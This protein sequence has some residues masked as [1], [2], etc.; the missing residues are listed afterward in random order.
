MEQTDKNKQY[1][2]AL[3]VSKS[4]QGTE[5]LKDVTIR[6]EAGTITGIVGRNGSGKS[7]FFKCLCG[8]MRFTSG[9]VYVN[10]KQIKDPKD[11][12]SIGFII[13]EPGFLPQ[14]TGYQNL[15]MLAYLK[16]EVGKARILEVLDKVG[17]TENRNK[18][19]G[20]YSMGMKQRLAFAQ[21]IM[22][23]PSILILDEPTNGL[24]KS[25]LKDIRALI[26]ELKNQG[27]VILLA[28]HNKEDILS[29]CD[30]VYEMEGGIVSEK[31]VF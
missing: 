6:C 23:D 3:K 13:E 19:V 17:L 7:V 26:A 21:A 30:K 15:K 12:N 10:G 24:D 5:V 20:K 14:Y 29:L 25:G 28:S 2:E 27:K 22:E 9:E 8:L 4:F 16:N 11:M 31:L 1:I 18:K